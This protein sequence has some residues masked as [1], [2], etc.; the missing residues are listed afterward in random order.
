MKLPYLTAVGQETLRL[1]P[2]AM[3]SFARQ[4][5]TPV[6]LGGQCYEPGDLLMA[7]IYLLHLRPD[8]Y[9]EPQHFRPERF[10]E[11]QFSPYEYM[12]FGAGVRRCVG[13][14]LA[15]MELKLVLATVLGEMD[16]ASA[17]SRPVPQA[18]RG[19]TLGHGAPVRLRRI[20]R[21]RTAAAPQP[22]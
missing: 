5:Q 3:L 7:C 18:R 14:A 19:V 20:P 12:P 16:F 21:Q 2:V 15:Q 1:H 10:L 9:P 11:R 4:V 13:A 8:L 22:L 6:E 17:N